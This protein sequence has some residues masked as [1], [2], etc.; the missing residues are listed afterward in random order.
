M[1]PGQVLA[2]LR[3]CAGGVL[4]EAEEALL[5]KW[6]GN[7]AEEALLDICR[8]GGGQKLP[9]ERLES[10]LLAVEQASLRNPE[11]KGM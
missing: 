9:P 2:S 4:T 8:V 5:G 1:H 6:E 10:A 11:G 3:N 7:T